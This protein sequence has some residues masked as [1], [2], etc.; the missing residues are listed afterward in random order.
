M[1]RK[2][3][4]TPFDDIARGTSL[5]IPVLIRRADGSEFDLTGYH[6]FFTLKAAQFDHD[7]DD[8]RALIAKE[9]VVPDILA[10]KGRFNI[11]LSSKE[12]WLHPGEY[13]FDVEL[14]KDHGV[15]RIMMCKTT[16]VGGPTNRTVDHE[17]GYSITM[18]DAFEVTIDKDKVVV[19]ETPL[20]SDPPEHL[21]ETIGCE[22]P[23]LVE[24]TD[25]ED[26]PKR[27]YMFRVFGPRVQFMMNIHQPHDAEEHRYRFDNFF[28]NKTL[29]KGCPLKDAVL[30]LRNRDI[31][32][33]LANGRKMWM[34]CSDIYVQH[35]PE[36]TF[37]GE[38]KDHISTD[39]TFVVGDNVSVGNIHIQ[40][41]GGNDQVDI[42][43]TYMM[44]D[45][46]GDFSNYMLTVAWYNWVDTF[47]D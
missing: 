34:D 36:I 43:G 11:V 26:K 9:V 19:I 29:P 13:I 20:V 27:N 24:C 16:I 18:S 6:I 23:Y 40:L 3:T 8:D 22:P 4:I 39:D 37:G 12:T 28:Y 31:H 15:N 1:P 45:D 30:V 21:V 35:S 5:T 17:E 42:S 38:Y 14:V 46:H 7:Y 47:D 41:E 33:E 10:Q 25:P 32:I 44:W 2:I